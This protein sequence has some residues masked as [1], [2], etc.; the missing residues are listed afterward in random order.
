[1][2][3]HI[4]IIENFNNLKNWEEKYIYLIEIGNELKKMP[5]KYYTSK[6]KVVG[7]QS[8]VWLKIIVNKHNINKEVEFYGD[9][10]SSIVKGLLSFV[11]LFYKDM[12]VN[13]IFSFNIHKYIKQTSLINNLTTS[14]S[15]GLK[16]IILHINNKLKKYL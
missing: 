5:N 13:E 3:K 8:T 11:F 9:S 15:Q 14:R 1:M 4:K 6:N 2:K 16:S 10:D 12:N 7:C